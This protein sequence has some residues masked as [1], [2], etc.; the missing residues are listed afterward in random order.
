MKNRIHIDDI[1]VRLHAQDHV[2]IARQDIPTETILI[3]GSAL[4]APVEIPV[5]HDIPAGHKIPIRVVEAGGEVRR[6]GYPIGNA[7]LRIEPGDW[8]HTHN[9]SVPEKPPQRT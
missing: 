6:Y 3:T 4:D 8:V 7:T 2:A 5:H 1:T 9:L